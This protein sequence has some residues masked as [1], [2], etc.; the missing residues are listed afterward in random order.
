MAIKL[1]LELSLI[2]EVE[3]NK[4]RLTNSIEYDFYFLTPHKPYIDTIRFE[5][6]VCTK[7]YSRTKEVVH[8]IDCLYKAIIR[9]ENINCILE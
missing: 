9:E 6:D 2:S 1:D 4:Y 5:D 7:V 8:A 3:V